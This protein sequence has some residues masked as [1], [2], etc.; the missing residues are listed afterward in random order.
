[1]S[2]K[3]IENIKKMSTPSKIA[4]IIALIRI[5]SILF[6]KNKDKMCQK[7]SKIMQVLFYSVIYVFILNWLCS[8]DWCWASWI[9]I[10]SQLIYILITLLLV[11]SIMGFMSCLKNNNQ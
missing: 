2:D 6:S 5:L 8:N 4:L 3:F 7:T 9:L 10:T 1:M 11:F